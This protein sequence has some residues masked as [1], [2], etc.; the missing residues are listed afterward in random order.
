MAQLPFDSGERRTPTSTPTVPEAGE[1]VTEPSTPTDTFLGRLQVRNLIGWGGHAEV[2]RVFDPQL[3]EHRAAKVLRVHARTPAVRE[4]FLREAQALAGLR[5]PHIA[6]IHPVEA[7]L[8]QPYFVME[9]FPRGSLGDRLARGRLPWREAVAT[10]DEV[11]DALAYIHARG[12]VHRD[13]KPDNLLVADD[14]TIKVSDFGIA[15]PPSQ[16]TTETL[17][18]LGALDDT[19]DGG[20]PALTETHARLGTR[21]FLAPEQDTDPHS[22]SAAA[23][24]YAAGATLGALFTG[25]RRPERFLKPGGKRPRKVPAP[26]WTVVVRATRTE[27]ERRYPSASAMAVALRRAARAARIQEALI[28]VTVRGR[29]VRLATAVASVTVLM[30]AWR[31]PLGAATITPLEDA[32]PDAVAP[33]DVERPEAPSVLPP[34][35][36]APVTS[37]PDTTVAS[38]ANTQD[39]PAEERRPAKPPRAN[40][41]SLAVSAP[42]VPETAPA[43]GCTSIK[44]FAQPGGWVTIDGGTTMR[45]PWT[46]CLRPGERMLEFRRTA[47]GQAA[48]VGSLRVDGDQGKDIS[49]CVDLEKAQSYDCG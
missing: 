33:M 18:E 46:A 37:V 42:T 4:R 17:F 41:T 28:G 31:Y 10:M 19:E 9:L 49:Y 22:V 7:E 2:F 5:H 30:I 11:L 20:R 43:D 34:P 29:A 8:D 6:T 3:K 24:V 15:L 48:Y 44:L 23:D 25:E 40:D 12:F 32:R 27:P 14:G 47:D 21:G 1:A 36:P 26:L 45:L 13:I 39:V 35:G 38:E 16:A